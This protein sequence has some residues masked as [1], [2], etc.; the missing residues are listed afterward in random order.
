MC[1]CALSSIF[2][3]VVRNSSDRGSYRAPRTGSRYLQAAE[4]YVNRNKASSASGSGTWGAS[5]GH[6]ARSARLLSVIVFRMFSSLCTNCSV[7]HHTNVTGPGPASP[8]TCSSL[9]GSRPGRPRPRPRS[10][11]RGCR[12]PAPAPAP[13]GHQ[14]SPALI[15][16]RVGDLTLNVKTARLVLL[17]IHC[18][19]HVLEVARSFIY[20]GFLSRMFWTSLTST[21]MSRSSREWRRSSL[22]TR[23]R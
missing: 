21:Q 10:T 18:R 19:V 5:S 23:P 13:R 1:L 15:L 22:P 2:V 12:P 9:R 11:A 16:P 4:A 8:L 7:F 20:L 17:V 6:R 3:S 14:R